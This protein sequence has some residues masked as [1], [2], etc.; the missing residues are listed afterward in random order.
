MQNFSLW[1]LLV[2]LESNP[3]CAVV[4]VDDAARD[5][6]AFA[7]K[8]LHDEIV[9]MGVHPYVLVFVQCPIETDLRNAF[10]RTVRG[11]PVD[12]MVGLLVEPLSV[13][14][15]PVG[16]IRTCHEAEGRHNVTF[17]IFADI[18]AVFPEIFQQVF[19]GG[20]AVDPLGGVAC[21]G[22]EFPGVGIDGFQAVQIGKTCFPDR[23]FAVFL[24]HQK[25]CFRPRTKMS[26]TDF[27][28]PDGYCF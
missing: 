5:E 21:P 2:G 4:G 15:E 6:A 3:R 17:G 11:Q 24:Y 10:V 9:P 16:R 19:S 27:T 8:V 14:N 18:E 13:L 22:H 26:M 12:D 7:Q 23:Q 1:L 20:I 28:P 25:M